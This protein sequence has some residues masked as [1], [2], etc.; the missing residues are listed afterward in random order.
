MNICV[1]KLR[2]SAPPRLQFCVELQ[3]TAQPLEAYRCASVLFQVGECI[4]M[5]LI[6]IEQLFFN[7]EANVQR[8]PNV[9]IFNA[10]GVNLQFAH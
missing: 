5:E 3:F 10:F 4:K 1:V 2:R 8:A 6:D 7:V 9:R